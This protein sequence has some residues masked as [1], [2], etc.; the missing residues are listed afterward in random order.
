MFSYAAYAQLSH[1]AIIYI[2]FVS[3]DNLMSR[4]TFSYQT[5]LLLPVFFYLK[6]KKKYIILVEQQPASYIILISG[7]VLIWWKT[8]EW[9]DF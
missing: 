6:K 8:C 3:V 5:K 2:I 1:A 4:I 7:C 9:E